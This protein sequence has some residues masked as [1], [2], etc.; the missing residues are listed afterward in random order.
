LNSIW[1]ARKLHMFYEIYFSPTGGTKKVA[2]ALGSAWEEKESIDLMKVSDE[3]LSR[4]FSAEDFC[5]FAVPVYAGRVPEF[6]IERIRRLRASGTHAAASV[7]YGN[8]AFDDALLELK[9][10]LTGCG[11]LV[12]AGVAAIAQHSVCPSVARG[13]PNP[14]DFRK[15]SDFSDRIRD[16]SERDP[17][18]SVMVP[19]NSPYLP[20]KA[21]PIHPVGGLTCHR[22]GLC[23]SQCPVKAIPAANP[24]R[25]N[26]SKCISCMHCV[27]V[28][29]FGSRHASLFARAAGAALLKKSAAEP[30]ENELFL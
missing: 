20:R 18:Q 16:A 25:V 12:V 26:S 24:Q 14:E 5:L 10:T 30:K 27:S 28:C 9:D 7:V 17:S 3:E 13:R 29:P 21:M 2:D 15:L 8:R 19:G 11:F 6:A 22:C 4:S 1:A 23:A